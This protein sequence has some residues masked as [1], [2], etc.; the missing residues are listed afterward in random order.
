MRFVLLVALAAARDSDFDR[1]LEL[2]TEAQN[3]CKAPVDLL[4][5]SPRDGG[6]A[7]GIHT[8]VAALSRSLLTGRVLTLEAKGHCHAGARPQVLRRDA[9]PRRRLRLR[10]ALPGALALHGALARPRH[11][12][13]ALQALLSNSVRGAQLD[14]QPCAVNENLQDKPPFFWASVLATYATRPLPCLSKRVDFL[15]RALFGD[16]PPDQSWRSTRASTAPRQRR[17][18]RTRRGVMCRGRLPSSTPTGRWFVRVL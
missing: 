5:T 9:V 8:V 14:V 15:E 18:G 3:D 4:R 12:S 1:A 2:V 11:P 16:V 7:S 6:F 17:P 13:D 10:D